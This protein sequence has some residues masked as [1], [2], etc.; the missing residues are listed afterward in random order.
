MVE[1]NTVEILYNLNME[2]PRRE[3]P[4]QS[5]DNLYV[6]ENFGP[7]FSR[8]DNYRYGSP[9]ETAQQIYDQT[10]SESGD[11]RHEEYSA[12]EQRDSVTSQTASRK[13]GG[14]ISLDDLAILVLYEYYYT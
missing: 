3:P 11:N 7:S 13:N 6:D 2:K 10:P 5:N 14:M 4:L 9:D 12:T 1:G 8:A